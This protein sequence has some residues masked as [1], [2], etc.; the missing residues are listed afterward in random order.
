MI[1]SEAAG[2]GERTNMKDWY[3]EV[4]QIKVEEKNEAQVKMLYMN[5]ILNIEYYK[6]K[7]K[8]T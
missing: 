6:N 1:A 2:Y 8:D 7:P 3:G 4:C 5:T